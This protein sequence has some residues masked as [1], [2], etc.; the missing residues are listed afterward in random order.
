M[1]LNPGT[2]ARRVEPHRALAL[3]PV[4]S[5]VRS[6]ARSRNDIGWIVI[7][8]RVLLAWLPIYALLAQSLPPLA[9]ASTTSL[10]TGIWLLPL[11][12]A[13]GNYFTL[14]PT[15]ASAAGTVTGLIA[16]SA[17][18][19][20]APGIDLG[21]VALAEAA[22]AVF[23]LSATWEHFVRSLVKHRV[24][25]I[26]TDGDAYEVM[27]ELQRDDRSPFDIVGVV[28]QPIDE[29]KRVVAAQRP[30][31]V[32]LADDRASA[33]AV[34]PLL[35]M[36]TMGFKIVGV[37]HF[38]EHAIGRVPLGHLTPAWFMS[39]LHLRQKPYTR[40]AKRTFDLVVASV[41][42]V[43]VAPLLPLLVAFVRMSPGP[44]IYTQIRLGEGGRRYRMYKFRTMRADAEEA[45]RPVFTSES[46]PRVTRV[47][48][49]LR[50]THLDEV[51]QLWNVM[52]GEM[53]IVGP[54]PERPEFVE[55][56]EETVPFWTRRLLVKP[57][58]TGWAQLRCGYAYDAES[59]A[60]KLSYDLWYLRHRNV[61][62]DLAIC[63]KTVSTLLF[64]PGR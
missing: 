43:L 14:G 59:A 41:S 61:V 27:Q 33:W 47:G 64:K 55:M 60:E 17:L 16:V 24:L 38:F 25:V 52:K 48:R 49:L 10:V 53:S 28:G 1:S 36:A 13:L 44:V 19:L 51:P 7:G 9:A 23:L 8:G 31:I 3:E 26:G 22:I 62:I 42:L 5:L 2:D 15:I 63:V 35:D 39:I 4:G 21:V 54:R 18:D 50:Q 20:W 58:I 45:G 12:A 11:R 46:D 37:S 57:G 32:I 29:L 34:E 40:L 56:L 30:D 6:F